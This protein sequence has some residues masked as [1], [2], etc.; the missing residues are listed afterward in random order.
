MRQNSRFWHFSLATAENK[1]V[2]KAAIATPYLN[3]P[4]EG[5]IDIS[6][7]DRCCSAEASPNDYSGCRPPTQPTD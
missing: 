3:W 6:E 2:L 7:Y 5:N 4:G 1:A